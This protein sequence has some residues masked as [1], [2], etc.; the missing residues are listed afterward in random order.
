MKIS[1]KKLNK[2]L[3]SVHRWLPQDK[4]LKELHS[5]LDK[6]YW[7]LK[8]NRKFVNKN[9]LPQTKK[10]PIIVNWGVDNVSFKSPFNAIIIELFETKR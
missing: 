2:K 10:R 8:K 5:I 9:G 1:D 4:T 6:L 7:D 3:K